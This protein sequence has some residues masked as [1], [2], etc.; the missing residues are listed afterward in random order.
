MLELES[1][2]CFSS[3]NIGLGINTHNI[4]HNLL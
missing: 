4:T 1:K 3:Y 2:T